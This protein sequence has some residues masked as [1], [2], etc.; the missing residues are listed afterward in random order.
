MHVTKM[1][2]IYANSL[3]IIL[4]LLL[5]SFHNNHSDSRYMTIYNF[6]PKYI[7]Q[8]VNTIQNYKITVMQFVL[9]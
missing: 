2:V 9:K 6:P 1:Q 8:N 7:V 5:T 4:L 3:L